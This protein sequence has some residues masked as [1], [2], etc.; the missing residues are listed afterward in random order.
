M[1]T[2]TEEQPKHSSEE[3]IILYN[4]RRYGTAGRLYHW[5]HAG[6]MMLFLSTG[7]QIYVGQPIFGDMALI[8]TIHIALGIFIIFWDLIVQIAIIAIDGH[9]WDVIPTLTDFADLILI[10]LCTLRIIDD[11]H[12]PHYD[13]YDPTLGA[14]VRKYHPAQKFL[15]IAD[16][17]AMFA[18]AVTGIAL[19]ELFMGFLAGFTLL[20]SWLIPMTM[21]NIRFFHFLLFLYF[22]LTTI[23]HVYFA[24]IPQNFG[25]LRAMVTGQELIKE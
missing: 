12:Y 24:L 6:A 8:R 21:V 25:R 1:I 3:A 18:M 9:S 4:V 22:L 17:L 19:A 13:F 15:S 7:W 10:L 20:V 5:V 11:K 16:I 23:F 14:Y 2:T